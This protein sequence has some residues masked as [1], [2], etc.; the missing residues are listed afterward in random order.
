LDLNLQYKKGVEELGQQSAKIL[1]L[2]NPTS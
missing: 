2:Y 1:S